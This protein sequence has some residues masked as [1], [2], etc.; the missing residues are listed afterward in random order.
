MCR[1]VTQLG[2]QLLQS[3]ATRLP[4][5]STPAPVCCP[6]SP[7]FL[8]LAVGRRHI[9][10][11]KQGQ[12][13][14][15]GPL[16]LSR[17]RVR[18]KVLFVFKFPSL[19]HERSVVGVLIFFFPSDDAR[20]KGRFSQCRPGWSWTHCEQLSREASRGRTGRR[21]PGGFSRRWKDGPPPGYLVSFF[22]SI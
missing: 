2:H 3:Q 16:C 19:D 6:P 1:S 14:K 8:G 7:G 17:F 22:A 20:I 9:P 18:S 4:P 21:V 15:L 5:P 13:F 11:L 10:C 12:L